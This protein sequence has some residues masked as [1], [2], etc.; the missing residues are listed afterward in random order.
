MQPN[1]NTFNLCCNLL[2]YRWSK[3][4]W[5]NLLSV[6]VVGEIIILLNA[7]LGI[8]WSIGF[9]GDQP[10]GV[11]LIRNGVTTQY[12]NVIITFNS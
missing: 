2:Y 6:G 9:K 5:I 3:D 4:E 7:Y 1:L 8:Q 12:R 10:F 11:N